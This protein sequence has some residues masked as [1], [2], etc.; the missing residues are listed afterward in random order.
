MQLKSINYQ[1]VLYQQKK[2]KVHLNILELPEFERAVLTIGTFDGVHLGHRKIIEQ[3]I[4]EAK[5]LDG[6][7]IVLT[8]FPHPKH[9]VGNNSEAI[10]LLNT[11][12]EKVELLREAGVDHLV[13]TPFTTAFA[14]LSAE[15]Y[16]KDFLVKSFH[17]HTLIIGYDHRFG[18][19]RMGDFKMLEQYSGEFGYK[20]MEVPE[21]ILAHIKISSTQI[22]NQLLLGNVEQANALLGYQYFFL[23][24]VIDGNKRGRT[25]GF[26]TANLQIS[27]NEKLIPADGVYAVDVKIEGADI[28]YIGMMN[29]GIK[30]TFDG[31][32]KTIE[33]NI[34]DFDE[35]IYGKKLTIFFKFKIRDEIKF[36]SVEALVMQLNEDREKANI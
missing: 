23:G 5:R 12:E 18:K 34:F 19:N 13:V 9:V 32:E 4:N 29:M 30:P 31:H 21:H 22:R 35:M 33:V 20:L 2:M 8:F 1:L 3:L 24:K 25:I 16:I 27:D 6:T 17:P 26:P 10:L 11:L 36:D 15:D 28:Q 14:E 7:S